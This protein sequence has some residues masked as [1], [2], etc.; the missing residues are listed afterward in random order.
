MAGIE[1]PSLSSN[2]ASLRAPRSGLAMRSCT[3]RASTA[4]GLDWGQD[5][6]G[7]M[8]GP[9]AAI[10]QAGNPVLGK[11]SLPQIARRARNFIL[12]AKGTKLLSVRQSHRKLRPLLPNIHLLPGHPAL[13]F[14]EPIF[15]PQPRLRCKACRDNNL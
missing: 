15:T 13:A 12:P 6:M 7:T 9:P 14:R 1:Q 3:I 8:L 11:P 10:L 4:S 2:E 5:S